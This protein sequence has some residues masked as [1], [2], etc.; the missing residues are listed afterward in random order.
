MF[1]FAKKS[2][3]RLPPSSRPPIPQ[4]ELFDK[5]VCPD[6]KLASFYPAKPG[7][8]LI[9]KFQLLVKIGWGSQLTVWLARDISGYLLTL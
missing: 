5:E 1:S 2:L 4:Q 3:W 9:K 6:Y 8:V 7:E